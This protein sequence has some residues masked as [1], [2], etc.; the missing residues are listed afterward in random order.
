MNKTTDFKSVYRCAGIYDAV[1]PPHYYDGAED[2]DLIARLMAEHYGQPGHGQALRVAEFGCGT[3][4]VTSRLSPYAGRLMA[5]D[6]SPSM[7]ETFQERYPNSQTWCLDTRQAVARMLD[8][9]TA[10]AFDVVCAFW[11][12]SYPLGDCFEEMTAEG[13]RPVPDQAAAR[14]QAGRL[15]R[16]LVALVAP[17][18]HFLV[19]FFDSQTREQRLVTR[20]WER[21]AP[22][23]DGDRG[24]TR[25]VLID[26]LRAA[27]D[28]GEGWL[29]HTRKGG[30]AVA[31]SRDAARAWFNHLH[32]K[33]LP[34]LVN[35]PDVQ[36]DITDFVDECTQ[37]SGEVIMPS[38]VYL[39]DFQVV[40]AHEHHLRRPR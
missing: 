2:V 38:G 32:L 33:D 17:Y 19:L 25:H 18:G 21:I 7:I 16:D 8:E 3:G 5:V 12:L 11:S 31:P 36:R 34:A 26:E 22:F 4:R 13:I 10:G 1:L 20:L 27:E 29:T 37:P 6:S 40:R 24:Y 39:I 15:V 30:V 14:E 35:D 9:G 23:P 28:K